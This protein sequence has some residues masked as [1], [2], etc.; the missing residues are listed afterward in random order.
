MGSLRTRAWPRV[1]CI[2]RRILNHCTTREVPSL[3]ILKFQFLSPFSQT[4]LLYSYP[5]QIHIWLLIYIPCMF[6]D[7]G[8][9]PQSKDRF[10]YFLQSVSPIVAEFCFCFSFSGTYI[11]HLILFFRVWSLFVFKCQNYDHIPEGDDLN[12]MPFR[13]K[14]G[15]PPTSPKLLYYSSHLNFFLLL[16]MVKVLHTTHISLPP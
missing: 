15:C 4:C 3:S 7:F 11:D 5:C 8:L 1:P 6:S 9:E 12:N 2:G 14:W 13:L 16:E 10:T